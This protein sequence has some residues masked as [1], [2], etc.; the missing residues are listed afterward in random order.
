MQLVDQHAQLTVNINQLPL[1]N[2]C[3]IG[4]DIDRRLD[5]AVQRQG[6]SC[7]ELAQ[8]RKGECFLTHIKTQLD[9]KSVV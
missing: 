9:R 3:A 6:L 7:P 4:P 1:S 8:L 2:Q 5:L